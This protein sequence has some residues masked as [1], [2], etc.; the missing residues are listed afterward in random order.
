MDRSHHNATG[1]RKMD[2]ESHQPAIPGQSGSRLAQGARLGVEMTGPDAFTLPHMRKRTDL[3][4]VLT[5]GGSDSGGGAGTQADLKTFA[6]LGVHGASAVT[7][8][9]A[10]NPKR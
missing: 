8:V 1:A 5:I 3:P 10:Q 9:T 2:S 7:C 4:V 6:F